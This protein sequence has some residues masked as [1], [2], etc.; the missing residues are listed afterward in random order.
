[1]SMSF[2]FRRPF[3]VD[4]ARVLWRFFRVTKSPLLLSPRTVMRVAERA[5]RETLGKGE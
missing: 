2:L 3:P 1:M 5:V 4:Q